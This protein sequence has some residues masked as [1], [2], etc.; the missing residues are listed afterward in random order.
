MENERN[1]WSLYGETPA[2][3]CPFTPG[4]IAELERTEELVVYVPKG[5]TAAEMCRR[6]QIRANVDFDADKL[7]RNVMVDES[8]WFITSSS[9]TPEHI[10]K[11][12]LA[13]RRAYEDEGLHGM[14]LRC[15]LAFVATFRLRFDKLPD[16]L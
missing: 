12:A 14:D 13:A 7:V 11:S 3:P 5:I 4:E 1:V 8:H 2:T 15:Y 10:Y 16:Q 9:P 6:W